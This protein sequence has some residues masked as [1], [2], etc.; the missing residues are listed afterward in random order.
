[1]V[2]PILLPDDK[3]DDCQHRGLDLRVAT[4]RYRL[5]QWYCI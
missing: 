2:A 1:M 4:R 3:N 5:C